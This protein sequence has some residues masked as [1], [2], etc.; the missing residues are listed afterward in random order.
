[1]WT[2]KELKK[3]QRKSTQT[4][5]ESMRQSVLENQFLSGLKSALVGIEG[6]IEQLVEAKAC[7]EL[8]K[9]RVNQ[10][11][12]I[13]LGGQMPHCRTKDQAEGKDSSKPFS[14]DQ[15]AESRNAAP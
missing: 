2:S 13:L 1:M 14:R 15:P 4:S 11:Q 7:F 12:S 3:L 5:S 6:S 8:A 9:Q 10:I